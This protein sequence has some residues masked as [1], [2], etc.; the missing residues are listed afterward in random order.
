MNAEKVIDYSQSLANGIEEELENIEQGADLANLM[1]DIDRQI[2]LVSNLEAE[3]AND[4]KERLISIKNKLSTR[5][6]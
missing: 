4:V 2:V 6:V 1:P 3:E 5:G